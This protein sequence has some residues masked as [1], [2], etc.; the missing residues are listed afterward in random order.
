MINIGLILHIL[1]VLTILTGILMSIPLIL[2]FYFQEQWLVKGMILAVAST[3]AV[4]FLIFFI[5]SKMGE[6]SI[7]D[8]Y[9][10]V[11]GAWLVLGL[12]GALP[13]YFTGAIP[14]FSDAF[15]ESVSG[16]TTT[17]STILTDIESFP[18][19]LHF[20]RSFSQ[21][22]GGMG[23]I[24]L[25]LA[26][27]PLLRIGGMQLFKA[28]VPGPTADK[29]TPRVNQTARLLWIVYV[30]ITATEILLLWAGGMDL[31]EAICHGFTTM[32]TGGFS[33]RNASIEGFQSDYVEFVIT[34]FMLLAGINFSLHYR[35][36]R[37]EP[38]RYF[39]DPE[40]KTYLAIIAGFTII[41]TV[42]N[43]LEGTYHSLCDSF[44]TGV[45]QV[46]SLITTTGYNSADY[47][48]WVP[49]SQKLL[50]LLMFVGGSAGSTG[51]GIKVIRLK[52][53]L[54]EGM[55]E[56]KKILH[57]NAIF[58]LRI[59]KKPIPSDVVNSITGFFVLYIAA[60]FLVSIVLTFFGLDMMSAMGASASAMGNI[61]PGFGLVGPTDNFA[62]IHTGG[63]WILS[64]TMILG[65][66]ELYTVLVVFTR[67]F[68]K[69]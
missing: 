69:V 17:G 11:T 67:S 26:I 33:T 20:W 64:L 45:F 47:E 50:F 52:V 62:F 66:L 25:S 19:S 12:F 28:E 51:G 38:L 1:G 30:G 58:H 13:Y 40:C 37:G 27:L 42:T 5:T 48:K 8:G 14:S 2:S 21:W 55:L 3:L 65:R 59:G 35:A 57:P 23:I 6:L 54:K 68:W 36:I 39:K 18:R 7:R 4:G 34:F 60:F 41:I 24:V 43:I 10:V 46:V 49:F 31:F 53:V 63:K 56:L 16:F 32:A 29:L 9:L 44:R 22:L 15:F 61:G